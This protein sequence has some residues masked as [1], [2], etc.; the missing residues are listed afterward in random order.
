MVVI[1]PPSFNFSPRIT[2]AG[3]P[4][5][6]QAFIAESPVEALCVGVLR[7]LAWLTVR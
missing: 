5:R 7:R 2:Q 1:L 6:V 4:V 3:E